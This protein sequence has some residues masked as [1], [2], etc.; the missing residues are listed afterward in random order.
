MPSIE[1]LVIVLDDGA[2][3]EVGDI[4]IN[5]CG[6]AGEYQ[7]FY[8]SELNPEITSEAGFK[9]DEGLELGECRIIYRNGRPV[10]YKSAL[11]GK[12]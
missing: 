1:E 6:S 12:L 8:Q 5:E 4:G 10:I 2:E 9:T 11:E 7:E 3:P